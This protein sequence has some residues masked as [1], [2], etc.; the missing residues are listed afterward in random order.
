MVILNKNIV[1]IVL[2]ASFLL[3]FIS[4]CTAAEDEFGIVYAWSND[5]PA[6][7]EGMILKIN[8]PFTVKVTIESKIDGNICVKLYEPGVTNVYEVVEGATEIDEFI[9][10]MNL[11][12]KPPMS[13][14]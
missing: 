7:V 3:I 12:G 1:R 5:E 10:N 8:E 14:N 9:D 6:T 11:V 13:G 4:N 2:I